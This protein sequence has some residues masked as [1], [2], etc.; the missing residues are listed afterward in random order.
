MQIG[1]TKK[2]LVG[3]LIKIPLSARQSLKKNSKFFQS[4]IITTGNSMNTQFSQQG[5]LNVESHGVL[6]CGLR[7]FRELIE[8]LEI[9]MLLR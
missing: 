7:L 8:N 9:E 3:H 6:S 4:L 2:L 1:E 5:S